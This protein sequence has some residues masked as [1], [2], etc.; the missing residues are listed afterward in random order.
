MPPPQVLAQLGNL[1]KCCKCCPFSQSKKQRRFSVQMTQVTSAEDFRT[2]NASI[3]SPSLS[4]GSSPAKKH[5]GIN[6]EAE[7]MMCMDEN[8]SCD[9]SHDTSPSNCEEIQI[10]VPQQQKINNVNGSN[11]KKVK[12]AKINTMVD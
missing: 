12:Y 3:K 5:S 10:V 8:V 7:L 4:N 2:P 9:I 1:C 6:G 11:N